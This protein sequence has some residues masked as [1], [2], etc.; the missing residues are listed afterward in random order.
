MELI[1]CVSESS[2]DCKEPQCEPLYFI[3]IVYSF[4]ARPPHPNFAQ[5]PMAS[6]LKAGLP[7]APR[8]PATLPPI[9]YATAAAAAVAPTQ[10]P[11]PPTPSQPQLS[12]PSHPPPV[13][14]TALSIPPP[15]SQSN[16]Q[17]QQSG[18]PSSPS[19]SHPSVT[20]PML[21][22]ASVSHQPDGSFYS[23]QD[24]PAL[25]EAGPSSAGGPVATSSPPQ[26]ASRKGVFCALCMC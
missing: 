9:R 8:P 10:P 23:G 22:S 16:T 24:S 18:V 17:D 25:S 2:V 3:L 1:F 21:S 6:I 5:Q 26:N 7:T 19:L 12:A 15:G 4:P 20:S 13:S 11:Q 14:A